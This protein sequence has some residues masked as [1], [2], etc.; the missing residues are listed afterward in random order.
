ELNL[1]HIRRRELDGLFHFSPARQRLG[2]PRKRDYTQNSGLGF[3]RSLSPR[4]QAL[5]DVLGD[6]HCRSLDPGTAF[7]FGAFVLD[8]R[9]HSRVSRILSAEGDSGGAGNLSR[10]Q[11]AGQR[12]GR[13]VQI[14][15][16]G[17]MRFVSKELSSGV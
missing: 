17:S 11:E 8:C 12:R 3:A 10:L 16:S 6:G 7:Y 14:S 5:G 9:S 15:L 13:K 1:R 4:G 2:R